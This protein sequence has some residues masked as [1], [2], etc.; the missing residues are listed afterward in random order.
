MN[1]YFSK[2]LYV[3]G[4]KKIRV[5]GTAFSLI[6][7]LLNA[8]LPIVGI[9]ENRYHTTGTRVPDIVS[10][11]MVAPFDL[12]IFILVPLIVYDMFSFM[13]E[14]SKSDFWHAIP[15]KRTCVYLS[16]MS[17]VLTW[18]LS[19]IIVST[20]V[21]S[22]LWSLARWYD[23]SLSTAIIG[24]LPYLV[25]AVF[26]AGVM[27][28]AMTVT[29]TSVS[30]FLVGVLF[31]L[32]FRVISIMFVTAL[33]EYSNL[34]Y[35]DYGIFKFFGVG[36]FL[37]LSLLIGVF[38]GEAEVYTN[39]G[40]MVYYFA[41][42]IIFLVLGCVSYN[43]RRSQSATK[44]APNKLL[45]HVYRFAVT[46]PFMF[47]VAVMI[48]IDGYDSYQ[49][50]L[51]M[52]AIL[53]YVLYELI[54]TKRIK[55]VVKSLPYIFVP[56]L[57]TVA[58][59]LAVIV[60]GN[61][62]DNMDIDPDDVEAY[63]FTGYAYDYEDF[64]TMDVFVTNEE[65]SEIIA[66]SYKDSANA[67][68]VFYDY[69]AQKKQDETYIRQKI[70]IKLDSGRVIARKV[71]F[72][73]SDYNK[74]KNILEKDPTYYAAYLSLPSPEEVTNVYVVDNYGHSRQNM[75]A[76]YKC[77]YDEY[78]TL[79]YGDKLVVKN[80]R[81][82]GGTLAQLGVSGYYGRNNFNSSYFIDFER[83]PKTA[84]LYFSMINEDGDYASRMAAL[85][86]TVDRIDEFEDKL[87]EGTD[88]HCYCTVNLSKMVGK[89]D[90]GAY[91]VYGKHY[92]IDA[93]DKVSRILGI[94]LE[95][96]NSLDNGKIEDLYLF[97][98]TLD[99]TVLMPVKTEEEIKYG[100]LE[101]VE[102]EDYFYEHYNFYISLDKESAERIVAVLSEFDTKEKIH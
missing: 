96:S 32:F 83:L 53:V 63:S 30:N 100:E 61:S 95:S 6:I 101:M 98:M 49:L 54:T 36:F 8:I 85:K 93:M 44:S 33:E 87:E 10:P 3:E 39:W 40:P 92:S 84:A 56:F 1:N 99:S 58:L 2:K 59:S 4:L 73:E 75:N 5:S 28:L 27:V 34:L 88:R 74:L 91:T 20:L 14:R 65:A 82:G 97:E 45:Q 71:C 17:A 37:P 80:S 11:N 25:L 13:N 102:I 19:T 66:R 55:S 48:I 77:F 69:M 81:R 31:L 76:L 70:L 94:I 38:D 86:R 46:L 79:S 60:V 24:T 43:K 16:L 52:L 26:M 90:D 47:L 12:L 35:A 89:F 15:Q 64:V 62:I 21:N 50:V 18:A 22:V 7:I 57:C 67:N 23:L 9:A 51:M 41:V 42:G 78:Q 68:E 29:G 72:W